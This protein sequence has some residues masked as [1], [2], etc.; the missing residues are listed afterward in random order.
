MPA[1]S[2]TTLEADRLSGSSP[3][4]EPSAFDKCTPGRMAFADR[5]KPSLEVLHP[6][7]LVREGAE[8][9]RQFHRVFMPA[10]GG[11]VSGNSEPR[12]VRLSLDAL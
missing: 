4:R 8:I 11:S 10:L 1:F 2:R 7:A 9:A 3:V 12:H 5:A 6:A